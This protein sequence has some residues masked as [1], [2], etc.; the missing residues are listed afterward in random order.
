M[1]IAGCRG[2]FNN[3]LVDSDIPALLREG[4]LEETRWKLDF[5]RN[6]LQLTKVGDCG[7]AFCVERCPHWQARF[8]F[9]SPWGIPEGG[10]CFLGGH[11]LPTAGI[12][13][14]DFKDEFRKVPA[15]RRF[16]GCKA[17]VLKNAP[18]PNPQSDRGIVRTLQ[19]EWGH[20][21]PNQLE[22]ILMFCCLWT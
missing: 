16:Q 14:L 13:F 10:A 22:R 12:S 4:A 18:N 15:P 19:S 5:P 21:S 9:A 2:T 7:E 17:P 6:C 1:A 11:G 8:S 3:F 20:A